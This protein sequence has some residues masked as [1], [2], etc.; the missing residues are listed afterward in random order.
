MFYV[1][2]TRK[3]TECYSSVFKYIEEKF[4]LEPREIITDFEQAMRKALNEQY[5]DTVLWGSW[6][7][8]CAALRKKHLKLGMNKLLK[9]SDTAKKIKKM[10]MSLPLLPP[11]NFKEGY[12]H[13][14]HSAK[15][16][17]LAEAFDN[18][19]KYFQSYW[20]LQV[21][22]AVLWHPYIFHLNI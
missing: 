14:K 9:E 20:F 22:L 12:E 10:L 18:V 21:I 4:Q 7:H 11:E 15:N 5:P 6:Y 13:I 3:T 19:F 16:W 17:N 2:M 8:Y 1:L